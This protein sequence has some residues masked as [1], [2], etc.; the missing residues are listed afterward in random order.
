M[1]LPEVQRAWREK[2][3]LITIILSI[4]G[5]VGFITFGFTE[6]VCRSPPARIQGGEATSGSVIVNGFA[7]NF[8][9]IGFQHPGFDG[10]PPSN[11]A[12]PPINAGGKDA[13]FLF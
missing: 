5:A 9:E 11:P 12:Y 10:Y 2:M 4:C 13:S 7:I 6:T 8:D 3:G 1:K